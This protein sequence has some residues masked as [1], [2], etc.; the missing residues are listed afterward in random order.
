M[1]RVISQ[2]RQEIPL[3]HEWGLS[4]EGYYP[5]MVHLREVLHLKADHIAFYE[6]MLNIVS[7]DFHQ[8]QLEHIVYDEKLHY[9]QLKEMYVSLAGKQFEFQVNKPVFV[10]Y[11]HALQTAFF[12][13]VDSC[14]LYKSLVAESQ[15]YRIKECLSSIA[16][17]EVKHCVQLSF[18]RSS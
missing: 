10:N 7:N 14:R 4:F 5:F 17:D 3:F 18:L 9:K 16:M 12:H 11:M 6:R 2:N 8:L 15:I 13:E 1:N